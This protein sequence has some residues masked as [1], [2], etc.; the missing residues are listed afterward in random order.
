M[1]HSFDPRPYIYEL[2]KML[3]DKTK[4][5]VFTFE[6]LPKNLNIKNVFVGNCDVDDFLQLFLNA[7]FVVTN[8]FHGTAFALNFGIPLYSIIKKIMILMIDK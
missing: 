8:S 7:S 2:L 5:D 3:Q 6:R 1:Y 4:Y